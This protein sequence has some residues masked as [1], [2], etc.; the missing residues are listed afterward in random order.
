MS[1]KKPL[2]VTEIDV[3]E[4]EFDLRNL[5]K[6]ADAWDPSEGEPCEHQPNG[7]MPGASC[8]KCGRKHRGLDDAVVFE[9]LNGD[10]RFFDNER[11][12]SGTHKMVGALRDGRYWTIVL[13]ESDP[14]RHV[15]RPITGWPSGDRE[16]QAWHDSK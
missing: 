5:D 4:L 10:P 9:V 3:A 16:Q 13:L 8:L 15:W 1:T 14:V 12:K 7:P 6:W 2:K 11:G